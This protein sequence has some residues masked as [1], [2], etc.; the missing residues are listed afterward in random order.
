MNFGENFKVISED[1]VLVYQ[2][3]TADVMEMLIEYREKY[4]IEFDVVFGK[5]IIYYRFHTGAMFEASMN[6]SVMNKE[7]F[8]KYYMALNLIMELSEKTYRIFNELE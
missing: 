1:K 6:E 8:Y 5:N 3:L 4:E 2:L 7:N